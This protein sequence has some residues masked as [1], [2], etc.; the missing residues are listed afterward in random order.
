M[1]EWI[2][3]CTEVRASEELDFRFFYCGF[4]NDQTLL[5]FQKQIS[6]GF[7]FSQ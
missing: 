1:L 4:F 7:F 6:S 5:G 3:S 2:T